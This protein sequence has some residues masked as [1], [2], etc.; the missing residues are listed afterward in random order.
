MSDI[1]NNVI[2]GL[3]VAALVKSFEHKHIIFKKFINPNKANKIS[4]VHVLSKCVYNVNI[5]QIELTK[6]FAFIFNHLTN[7]NSDKICSY[8]DTLSHLTQSDLIILKQIY[9][10]KTIIVN[11]DKNVELS[12]SINK[13]VLNALIVKQVEYF[14]DIDFSIIGTYQLTP[15]GK[16]FY[17]CCTDK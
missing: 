5:S 12:I 15:V 10:N 2:S 13:L 17:K 1:L 14:Y 16:D 11:N 7:S 4:N 8:I 6:Y 9:E 3:T